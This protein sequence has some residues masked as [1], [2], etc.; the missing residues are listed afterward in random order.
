[1]AAV[2]GARVAI[3]DFD[4]LVLA[5]HTGH[6]HVGRA[7][8]AVVAHERLVLDAGGGVAAVDGAGVTVVDGRGGAGQAEPTAV[9]RLATI[10]QGGVVTGRPG[11]H[12]GVGAVSAEA[13][14]V[15][16]RVGVFALGVGGANRGAATR[17]GGPRTAR[18]AAA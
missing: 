5:P 10:A 14:V 7:R 4:R 16:T 13:D 12:E 2:D 1:M 8:I 6:A 15:G 9:A 3:V 11:R 17:I 18:G